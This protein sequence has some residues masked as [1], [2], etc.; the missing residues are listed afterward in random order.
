MGSNLTRKGFRMRIRSPLFGAMGLAMV[1]G[2]A[3]SA[4]SAPLTPGVDAASL[5]MVAA[6]PATDLDANIVELLAGM[7]GVQIII[8]VPIPLMYAGDFERGVILG[9]ASLGFGAGVAG[10][11]LPM[12]PTPP[13]LRPYQG[14]ATQLATEILSYRGPRPGGRFVPTPEPGAAACFAVG[15]LLVAT[16]LR[17]RRKSRA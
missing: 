8:A 9:G 4:E 11:P 2:F 3:T 10:S 13:G 17:G 16:Q 5:Y 1:L 15:F 6:V 14:N 12:M 7:R